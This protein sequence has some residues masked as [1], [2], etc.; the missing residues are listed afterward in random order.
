MTGYLAITWVENSSPKLWKYQSVIFGLILTLHSNTTGIAS[1]TVD[2]WQFILICILNECMIHIL[3]VPLGS[4]CFCLSPTFEKALKISLPV[5]SKEIP[6]YESLMFNVEFV[7][8]HLRETKV[9]VT[10]GELTSLCLISLLP[11]GAIISNWSPFQ[12][13]HCLT[14]AST[15]NCTY[16]EI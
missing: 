14:I 7:C 11:G 1:V 10:L 16:L 6:H 5:P 8:C 12:P 3:A 9:E 13:H 15:Q 2:K 4:L